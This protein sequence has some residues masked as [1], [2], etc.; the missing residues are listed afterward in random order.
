MKKCS[1]DIEL[2]TEQMHWTSIIEC[3]EVLR[4]QGLITDALYNSM[5]EKLMTLKPECNCKECK[6]E[7]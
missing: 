6:G 2:I 5:F 4:L 7:K 1:N 3:F